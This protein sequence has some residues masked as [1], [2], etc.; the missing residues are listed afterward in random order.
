MVTAREYFNKDEEIVHLVQ[1]I[2]DRIDLSG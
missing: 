1:K 2:W